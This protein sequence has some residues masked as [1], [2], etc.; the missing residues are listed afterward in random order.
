VYVPA[1]LVPEGTVR[2]TFPTM[3]STYDTARLGL[4]KGLSVSR[5]PAAIA[6]LVRTVV[7]RWTAAGAPLVP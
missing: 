5:N 4:P 6:Y 1:G 3:H 2:K 7:N